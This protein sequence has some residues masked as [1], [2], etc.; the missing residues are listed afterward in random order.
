MS[1]TIDFQ[2]LWILY[3]PKVDGD[4]ELDHGFKPVT[5]RSE[6]IISNAF[7]ER[8][9][10]GKTESYILVVQSLGKSIEK[11]QNQNEFMAFA[12]K[13]HCIRNIEH[14]YARLLGKRTRDSEDSKI[15]RKTPNIPS[16]SHICRNIFRT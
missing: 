10:I 8:R 7:N 14:V 16:F 9:L 15:R 4:H 12:D 6:R 2:L 3:Y 5:P 11:W 1:L 13:F